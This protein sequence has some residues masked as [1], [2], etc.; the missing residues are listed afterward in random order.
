MLKIE[1]D[2]NCGIAMLQPDGELS[3][4]DFI[5]AAEV[6][7]PYIERTG[8]LTGLLIHVQSFPGWESFSSLI[9]HLNFIKEHHRRVSR[10]AFAT[11]SPIGLFAE[12]IATHFVNAEIRH[13]EFSE[14]EDARKWILEGPVR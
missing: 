5:T 3:E 10:I 11:D 8:G 2:E 12:N 4:Q 1:I 9:A 14:L 7:D 13:F 6:I